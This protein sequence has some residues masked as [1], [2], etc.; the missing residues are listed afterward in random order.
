[1]IWFLTVMDILSFLLLTLTHFKI[2]FPT[3]LLFLSAIYLI[4]KFF[5][6]RDVMSA[7]D[8]IFGIYIIIVLIFHV[9]S[10]IYYFAAAWFSYKLLSTFLSI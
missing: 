3:Y 4:L 6:F 1:M 8:G 10:F 7:I 5:F 2:V 9:S